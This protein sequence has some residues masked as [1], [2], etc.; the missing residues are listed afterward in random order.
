MA[1]LVHKRHLVALGMAVLL[2]LA[3]VAPLCVSVQSA[4]AMPMPMSDT[5]PRDPDCDSEGSFGS[6]PHAE[7]RNLPA[8]ATGFDHPQLLVA[9]GPAPA[10]EVPL[11]LGVL[12]AHAVLDA[13]P[14]PSFL[15]PLRV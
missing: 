13:A 10:L 2:L 11:A 7:V 12:D 5:S 15:T 9:E 8:T 14:P 1:L 4:A 3:V 6:C